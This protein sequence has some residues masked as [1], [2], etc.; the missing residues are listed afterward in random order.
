M[1]YKS[2]LKRIAA[3]VALN[4][5]ALALPVLGGT[6]G[7]IGGIV[8]ADSGKPTVGATVKVKHIER[9]LTFMVFSKEQGRYRATDLPSGRYSVEAFGGGFQSS[10]NPEVE[11]GEGRNVTADISLT[12]RQKLMDTMKTSDLGKLLPEA[13]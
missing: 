4:L 11:V 5:F 13:A 7:A 1:R 2:A 8:K 10:S 6:G 3:M 12:T 9:G